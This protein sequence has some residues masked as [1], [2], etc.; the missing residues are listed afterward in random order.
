MGL[1]VGCPR[2]G[3]EEGSSEIID[4]A[5]SSDVQKAGEGRM[6]VEVAKT[7]D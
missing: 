6:E 7:E 3:G 5:R 1:T 4:G 2:A